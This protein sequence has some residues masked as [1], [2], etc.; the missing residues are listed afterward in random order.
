MLDI[1]KIDAGRMAVHLGP[2]SWDVLIRSVTSMMS[3]QF[4]LKR[5]V[6]DV[7][8]E[9]PLKKSVIGDEKLCRQILFNLLS[10]AVK[11]TPQGGA[12][13][14]RA[15][16]EEGWVRVSVSDTGIGI[17]LQHQDEIFSEFHQLDGRHQEGAGIGLALTRRLVELLGGEIGVESEPGVGSTFT[18]ALP[19]RP[20]EASERR[21]NPHEEQ[22]TAAAVGGRRILVAEDNEVN[23]AMILDMLATQG[24]EVAAARNGQEAVEL[25]FSL[26]PELILMDIKM[27]VMDGLEAT[28]R[29]RQN[30]YLANTPIVALTA[31]AGQE[32]I[33]RCLA[34][35]CSDHLPKPVQSKELFAAIGTRLTIGK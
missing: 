14:V 27:P 10:N 13:A 32:D 1:A 28:R 21:S 29:I 12:V 34:A 26:R 25:A 4:Q 19:L 3:P 30:P 8:V 7:S 16:A 33:E 23:L 31:R 2:F 35:G 5:L 9:E 15:L 17:P 6:L 22:E 11:F 24:S 20:L 18:F